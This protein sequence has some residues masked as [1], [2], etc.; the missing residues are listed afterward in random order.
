M[1]K[2][3]LQDLYE[4]PHLVDVDPDSTYYLVVRIRVPNL[5]RLYN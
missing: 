2:N 4:D 3:D 5:L 1:V